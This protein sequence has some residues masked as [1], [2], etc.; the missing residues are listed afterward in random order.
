MVLP[1]G[2]P[3]VLPP[4]VGGVDGCFN[5]L[6]SATGSWSPFPFPLIHDDA[7]FSLPTFDF[8]SGLLWPLVL[9]LVLVL[10]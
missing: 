1:P 4:E 5:L 10:V 9:V 8:S 2:V 7:C 3:P 6:S